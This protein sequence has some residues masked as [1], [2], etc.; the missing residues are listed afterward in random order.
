MK[1][2]CLCCDR[3]FEPKRS[4]QRYCCPRCRLLAWAAAELLKEYRAG[5]IPGL[6][7]LIIEF[8]KGAEK[9]R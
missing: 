1:I 7:A 6:R 4:K 8:G 9:G 5:K 3:E 2:P